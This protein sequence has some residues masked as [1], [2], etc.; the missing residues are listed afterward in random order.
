MFDNMDKEESEKKVES[1]VDEAIQ[2]K[3]I[4][5][6]RK[7]ASLVNKEYKQQITDLVSNAFREGYYL[8]IICGRYVKY[9]PNKETSI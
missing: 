7:A 3:M 1:L 2:N 4:P 5:L 8:G 9:E 6:M